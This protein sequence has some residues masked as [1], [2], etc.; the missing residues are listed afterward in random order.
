MLLD[1]RFDAPAE[2]GGSR[3]RRRT[4]DLTARAD[5][6]RDERG[7][8]EL[9]LSS[10]GEVAWVGHS[11]ASIGSP[12]QSILYLRDRDGIRR[13]AVASQI[14]SVRFSGAAVEWREDGQTRSTRG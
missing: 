10:N 1:R 13:L 8:V 11:E 7:L 9:A 12:S 5:L 6:H 14:G 2:I 3:G 4:L